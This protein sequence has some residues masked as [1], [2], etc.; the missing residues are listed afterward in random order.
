MPDDESGT[1]QHRALRGAL[2]LDERLGHIETTLA[3]LVESLGA[4]ATSFAT[5]GLRV[6]I[7]E[8]I[9]YGACGL[10]LTALAG[11][12]IALVVRP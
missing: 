9:V 1:D 12:L 7:L 3:K 2:T 5:L 10:G 11:A 4:G 6:R 8:I